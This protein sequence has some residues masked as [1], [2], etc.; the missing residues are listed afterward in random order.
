MDDV[1][2][3]VCMMTYNHESYIAQAIESVLM[4]RTDFKYELIIGEDLSTDKTRTICAKYAELF[5]DVVKLIPRT[6]NLGMVGN[7]VDTIAKCNTKYVALLEG[8]DCWVDPRKLQKQV[9]FLEREKGYSGCYHDAF[10]YYEDAKD[11]KVRL[12][13]KVAPP[14]PVTIEE[15]IK[16]WCVPTASLVFRREYLQ[17]PDWF[18]KI[19]N[20]DWAIEIIMADKAP[21]YYMD[22]PMSVYRKHSGGNSFNPF[23]RNELTF[24]RLIDLLEI[25]NVHL[26]KKYDAEIRKKIEGLHF[27]INKIG[28][29]SN[30]KYIYYITHPKK[31]FFGILRS[32]L[33]KA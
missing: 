18:S 20:W 30:N 7:F 32:I 3:S 22:E 11:N 31:L 21:M 25:L 14:N 24:K 5:P 27:E 26:N 1:T 2:V 19:Y 28:Q 33:A 13:N 9:D 8:D 10:V 4:Q 6:S 17:V 29:K 12:F 15:Y 23:Y 16:C